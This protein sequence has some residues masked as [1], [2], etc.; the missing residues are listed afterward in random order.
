MK[1][2]DMVIEDFLKNIDSITPTPGGGSASAITIA[3]G[4]SLIRMVSHI[5][6]S[7]KKFLLLEENE[8]NEY[9]RITENLANL[10]KEALDLADADSNAYMSLLA[11][12]R[13]PKINKQ[14]EM[15][16]K[17]AIIDATIGAAEVPYK[18]AELSYNA[19]KLTNKLYHLALK[20]AVSDIGVGVLL[21][22]AG[23]LGAIMNV[24]INMSGFEKEDIANKYINKV[25][26]LKTKFLS[27]SNNIMDFVNKQI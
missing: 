12:F 1:F 22:K 2:K 10:K 16:R 14:E 7:K 13:L 3:I 20:S 17:A 4:I 9:L 24:E 5:T 8:R 27:I 6:S 15:S 25:Q 23:F 26:T 18:I 21:L 19:L 11:A